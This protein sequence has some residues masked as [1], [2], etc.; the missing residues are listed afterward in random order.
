MSKCLVTRLNEVVDNDHLE[1]LGK[2]AIHVDLSEEQAAT[3]GN[4]FLRI[5]AAEGGI[6]AICP[7]GE[8]MKKGP[9]SSPIAEYTA[10]NI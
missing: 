5:V 6:T 2:L 7:Q 10:K 3:I 4:R 1:F 9:S 8:Y